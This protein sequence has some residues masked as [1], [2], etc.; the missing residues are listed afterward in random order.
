[1]NPSTRET[2]RL[3]RQ[4]TDQVLQSAQDAVG[5]SRGMARHAIEGADRTV[6]ELRA[7][8]DPALEEIASSAQRLAHRSLDLASDT[9]ARAQRS[10]RQYA[11]ATER[12]VADQP[13]RSILIAAAAGAVIAALAL[14]ARKRRDPQQPR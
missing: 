2:E 8:M 12:Y 11:A 9:S 4:L 5:S 3:G 7:R 13:V 10:L 6:R 1:M 14:A